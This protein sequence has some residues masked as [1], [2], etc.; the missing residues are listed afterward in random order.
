M[1]PVHVYQKKEKSQDEVS[2]FLE[3]RETWRY[4]TLLIVPQ[5]MT[6][7]HDV[8]PHQG[9]ISY[10][11]LPMTTWNTISIVVLLHVHTCTKI[12]DKTTKMYVRILLLHVHEDSSVLLTKILCVKKRLNTGRCLFFLAKWH[13][14]LHYITI[15]FCT[16]I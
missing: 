5:H 12:L 8:R 15:F 1:V 13:F 2:G 3:S 14:Y 9:F 7:G 11:A 10:P 6:P 16:H 4:A